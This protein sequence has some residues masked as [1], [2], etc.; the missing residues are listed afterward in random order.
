MHV[1]PKGSEEM[2][3]YIAKTLRRMF[4][5]DTIFGSVRILE[6]PK[7]RMTC[8]HTRLRHSVNYS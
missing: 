8:M 3:V 6:F 5:Y 1:V 7:V 4:S 2:H